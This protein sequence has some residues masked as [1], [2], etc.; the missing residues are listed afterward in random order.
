MSVA[1]ITGCG[2]S[3]TTILGSIL[4]RHQGVSYLN[5]RF[6]VWV[7][8][9]AITDIWGRRFQSEGASPRIEL[10]AAD[11]RAQSAAA[12]ERFFE[13][14]EM[15]RR[16]RQVLIEKLAINNFRLGFL[17]ELC[18]D[19]AVINIV[20]HGVEVAH[21]IA[22]RAQAGRWYGVDERKWKLL[23]QHAT[24]RGLEHLIPRCNTPLQRGLLEWRLSVDAADGYLAANPIPRY[25]RIRYEDL[26]ANPVAVCERVESL[27][28]LPRSEEVR[29]FAAAEVRRQSPT[30][31]ELPTVENAE[32]IAGAALRR[33]GYAPP[34]PLYAQEPGCGPAM[35]LAR[36]LGS[37]AGAP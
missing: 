30:S 14:L 16:R 29:S 31:G 32:V 36:A 26:I 11:A 33:L 8:P 23:V 9:F 19:A 35:P 12:R 27:L 25:L 18:P 24:E 4:A 22:K 28:G 7:R 5:D 3:G 17:M 10:T 2:R 1:F 6:D 20:R 37:P 34:A 21:S 13:L 15:E